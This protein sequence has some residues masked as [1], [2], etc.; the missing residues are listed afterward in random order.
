M[1]QVKVTVHTIS[2]PDRVFG[3]LHN[4]DLHLRWSGGLKSISHQGMLKPG[5]TYQTTH[6]ML[7]QRIDSTNRV[8]SV[9]PGKLLRIQN[10]SGPVR[11]DVTYSLS[12][13]GPGTAITCQ[14]T[15]TSSH[16]AFTLA[17]PVFEMMVEAQLR[18]DLENLK[19]AAET[20]P[21][22]GSD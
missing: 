6:V 1:A 4:A 11:Y 10:L 8:H 20:I 5:A 14:S 18:R 13:A 12:P 16:V 22:T 17:Q 19:S 15:I 3:L 2:P 9:I 7:G 21:A